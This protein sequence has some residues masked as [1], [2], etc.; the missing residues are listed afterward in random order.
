MTSQ[1]IDG[2][3]ISLDLFNQSSTR[4][5]WNLFL[6]FIPLLL[7]FY[8]FRPSALRNFFWW[9]IFIVFIVFLP[10]APY[11]LTDSIH[12]IELSQQS[13]P[14]WSII[15]ILIPQ[16]LV[17]IVAGFEAYVISLTQLDNYLLNQI[18]RSNLVLINAIAHG[19]CVVGIYLGRFE[20]FNSWD[21]ITK[22]GEVFLTTWQ[23][24][25]D[26]WKLFTLAIAFLLIWLLS[27]LTKLVNKK[28]Q[29]FLNY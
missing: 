7:S 14:T 5:I 20:R 24:L 13:Y 29:L 21:L 11:I 10:N 22:P 27:E 25:F 2:I 23:D 9:T 17:F 8:L 26:S 16:Y 15:S 18:S 12:I 28:I 19:L 3:K 4:I 1:L 6:A